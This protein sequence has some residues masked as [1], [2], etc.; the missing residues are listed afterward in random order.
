MLFY[1]TDGVHVC[2]ALTVCFSLSVYS[3][4]LVGELIDLF[5]SDNYSVFVNYCLLVVYQIPR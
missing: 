2:L 5:F 1:D 3:Q 4:G